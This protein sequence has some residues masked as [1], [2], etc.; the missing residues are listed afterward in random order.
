MI[1]IETSVNDMMRYVPLNDLTPKSHINLD[2][3]MTRQ[4][5]NTHKVKNNVGGLIIRPGNRKDMFSPIVP[6]LMNSKTV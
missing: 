1:K 4:D 5:A 6:M 2:L 3:S